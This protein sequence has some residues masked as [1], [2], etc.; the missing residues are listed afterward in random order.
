MIVRGSSW[1]DVLGRSIPNAPRSPF[2]PM[3][4]PIP[5]TIPTTEATARPANA[6]TTTDVMT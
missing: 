3:A 5:A 4:I 1:S 2:S 6:S